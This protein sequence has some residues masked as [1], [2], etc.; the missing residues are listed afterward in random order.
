MPN[1]L[2]IHYESSTEHQLNLLLIALQDEILFVD[3]V[4]PISCEKE[5]EEQQSSNDVELGSILVV[6][7][8]VNESN[9]IILDKDSSSPVDGSQL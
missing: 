1:L 5:E 4:L 6:G 3:R 7:A 9:D 2:M 8:G